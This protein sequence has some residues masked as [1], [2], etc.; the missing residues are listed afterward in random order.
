[1]ST[2]FSP[3][4]YMEFSPDGY[5]TDGQDFAMGDT[6][7]HVS[8]T[9]G[10]TPGCLSFLVPVYDEGRA[11]MAA[12]WGGTGLPRNHELLQYRQSAISFSKLCD[13]KEVDV[14]IAT[15]PFVDN[16]IER[17]EVVSSIVDGVANPYV[18]GRD[19]CR[20]YEQMFLNLCLRR[21]EAE[22]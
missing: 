7:V 12:L 15:H 16:R 10:H 2:Q 4:G 3:F 17:F 22:G 19:N 1:M 5:L 18:I 14:E 6:P 11:H 8:L 13:E 9:P 21:I 20:R